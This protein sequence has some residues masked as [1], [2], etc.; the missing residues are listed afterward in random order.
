MM[1]MGSTAGAVRKASR[2]RRES[3]KPRPSMDEVWS[4]T[5]TTG[6]R[7]PGFAGG[8]VAEENEDWD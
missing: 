2:A 1:A 3:F 8:V 7:Y 4:S 5:G 6:G